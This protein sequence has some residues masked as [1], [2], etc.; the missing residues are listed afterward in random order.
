MPV[1]RA[2]ITCSNRS[3]ARVVVL[4]ERFQ[5]L[6]SWSSP[7]QFLCV[8]FRFMYQQNRTEQRLKCCPVLFCP[9]HKDT[10]T[11]Q[12]A[13]CRGEHLPSSRSPPRKFQVDHSLFI[14][15]TRTLRRAT[16]EGGG[17]SGARGDG[18]SG[19]GKTQ[20]HS[21][22]RTRPTPVRALSHTHSLSPSLPLFP[23]PPARSS[24][25]SSSYSFMSLLLSP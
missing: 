2:R 4:R 22:S 9:Q 1:R 8:K 12:H 17:A 14:H 20:A 3:G 18:S 6:C 13:D 10:T 16:G 23:C 15:F 21:S 7:L 11:N 19:D 25:S 24:S 5:R